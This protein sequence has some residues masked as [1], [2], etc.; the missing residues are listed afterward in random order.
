MK[1]RPLGFDA[2][3]IV[4]VNMRRIDPAMKDAF[5]LKVL[6]HPGVI[7]A[8]K[9]ARNFVN[10]SSDDFITKANGD[11]VDVHRYKIDHRYIPAIGLK[12]IK[13]R[14]FTQ[15]EKSSNQR[16]GNLVYRVICR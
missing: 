3:D 6:E 4:D 14:N 11:Q 2:R 5:Q 15:I 10:G 12:I 13:G 16:S 9:T 1:E 8:A 7:E